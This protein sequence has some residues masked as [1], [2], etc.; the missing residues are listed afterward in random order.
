MIKS[1][2]DLEFH[3]EE[4]YSLT[5]QVIR[6]SRS[7][8]SSI[9]EGRAKRTHE[10]KFKMNLMDAFGSTTETQNWVSFT[11]DFKYISAKVPNQPYNKPDQIGK[12]LLRLHQNWKSNPASNL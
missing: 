5:S 2:K 6:S 4:T 1:Y 7:I 10:N 8:S 12:M 11:K 3:N 9:A